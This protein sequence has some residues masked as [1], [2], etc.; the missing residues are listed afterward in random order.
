MAETGVS[1]LVGAVGGAGTTRLTLEFG[2]TLAREGD[3]VLVVDAAFATQGLATVVPGRINADVTTV[4][5]EDSPLDVATFPLEPDWGEPEASGELAVAPARAPFERFSRAMTAACGRRLGT[6][7]S[8]ATEQY[9]HVLVDVP[10]VAGN[11]AVAAVTAADRVLVVVPDSQ[12][13]ADALPRARDRLHD[14]D[15][16]VRGVV[17]NRATDPS[18]VGEA[19]AAVPES[20]TNALPEAPVAVEPSTFALA[21]E[22]AV[23]T[24]LDVELA[25]PE[26][27]SSSLSDYLTG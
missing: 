18:R 26:P 19:D 13:G 23:E 25:L 5:T 8:S 27:E 24:A 1:A 2:A 9:D 15:A 10:P 14:I 20:E 16:A 11:Q 3:A 12:R 22:D 4:V 6:R 17:T 21:V 7:L